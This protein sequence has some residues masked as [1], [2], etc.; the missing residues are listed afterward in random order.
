MTPARD[1]ERRLPDGG[2]L[3]I[4]VLIGLIFWLLMAVLFVLLSWPAPSDPSISTE[5]PSHASE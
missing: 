3:V 2:G 1:P 4:G 5:E